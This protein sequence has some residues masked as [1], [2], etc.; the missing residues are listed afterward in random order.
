MKLLIITTILFLQFNL[1]GQEIA[2]GIEILGNDSIKLYLKPHGVL[3][4]KECADYYRIAKVNHDVYLFDGQSKDYYSSGQLAV[5]CYYQNNL[6]HGKYVSFYSNGQIKETGQFSR[7]LKVGDWKYWHKNGQ[8]KKTIVFKEKDYFLREYY[9]RNGKQLII[10]G[11]GKYRETYLPTKIMMEGEVKNGKQHGKWT[12]SNKILGLKTGIEFFENGK[13]IEGKNIALI[14]DFSKKYFDFPKSFIDLTT[15]LLDAPSTTKTDCIKQRSSYTLVMARYNSKYGSLPFYDFVY[16]NFDPQQ[17]DQGYILAGFTINQSGKLMNIST[18]STLP[19]K[20]VTDKLILVLNSSEKWKPKVVNG[21]A[22]ESTKL[23][24]LQFYNGTYKILGDSRNDYP[25]VEYSSQFYKGFDYLV[26][27]IESKTTLPS[28]FKDNGFNLSTSISFHV[29]KWG[30]CIIDNSVFINKVRVT[31]D[32]RS[33]NN[34]LNAMFKKMDGQ[35]KPATYGGKPTRHYFTGTFN[36]KNG[37][38]K[39]RLLSNNWVLN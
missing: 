21:E 7:G 8:L 28:N 6:L 17:F 5:D 13:F 1:F 20:S 33:L 37:K 3:V 14:Q 22:I 12:I 31:D 32:E 38:T 35:W 15:D 23:F 11:N 26:D 30:N 27:L 19:D 16:Q 25:P 29:N 2:G 18:Y 34:A 36:I 4:D 10:D 24:V 39:F 9:K